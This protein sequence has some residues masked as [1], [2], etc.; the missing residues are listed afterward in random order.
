M[1]PPRKTFFASRGFLASKPSSFLVQNNNYGRTALIFFTLYGEKLF[2]ATNGPTGDAIPKLPGCL[3][4]TDTR[5]F[6]SAPRGTAAVPQAGAVCQGCHVA[7]GLAAGSVLFRPFATNGA[8]YDATKMG[9][10]SNPDKKWWDLMFD[11]PDPANPAKVIETL[12]GYLPPNLPATSAPVKVADA[13][14]TGLL[15]ASTQAPKSCVAT[16]NKQTPFVSV[17]NLGQLV[18]EYLKNSTSFARG[19][20]RHAQRAFFNQ[21]QVTLEMSVRAS[22]AYDRGEDR[23]PDLLKAYLL[24]DTLTCEE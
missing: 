15:N 20:T 11:Q 18:D 8:V 4:D 24:S 16:G 6:T 13:Y 17:A 19:F 3:E 2:A 12:W 22:S 9:D 1:L 23:L 10:V 7:R 5:T 14:L 21:T